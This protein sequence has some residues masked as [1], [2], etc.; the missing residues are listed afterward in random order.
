MSENQG[1]PLAPKTNFT[2]EEVASF[3]AGTA[4]PPNVQASIAAQAG[5]PGVNPLQATQA[6]VQAQGSLPYPLVDAFSRS[7]PLPV[8]YVGY[9]PVTNQQ[10]QSAY[11]PWQR[12]PFYDRHSSYGQSQNFPTSNYGSRSTIPVYSP[13]R[14]S[15]IPGRLGNSNSSGQSLQ[16]W[17]EA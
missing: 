6:Q 13:Q 10:V 3:L 15:C 2:V 12:A 16:H 14:P 5:R 4:V 7:A 9:P 17:T 11:Y 8:P 1:N